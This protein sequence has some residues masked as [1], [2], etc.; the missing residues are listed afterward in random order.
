MTE[1]SCKIDPTSLATFEESQE[2][3]TLEV[4]CQNG[5]SLSIFVSSPLI[6]T[7]SMNR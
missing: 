7:R 5:Q 6:V 1:V 2:A 4:S 3:L